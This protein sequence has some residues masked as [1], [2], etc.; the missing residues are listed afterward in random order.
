MA[1]LAP[2]V[3]HERAIGSKGKSERDAIETAEASRTS[4]AAIPKTIPHE[5]VVVPGAAH[6][7]LLDGCG[8]CPRVERFLLRR[9][10]GTP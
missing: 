7:D 3:R 2:S 1:L 9:L 5:L 6:G 8:V 4:A 10:S